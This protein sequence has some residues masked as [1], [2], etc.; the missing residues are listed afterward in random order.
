MRRVDSAVS[1]PA[2]H[3]WLS[4]KWDEAVREIARQYTPEPEPAPPKRTPADIE[5]E[6]AVRRVLNRMEGPQRPVAIARK[7]GWRTERGVVV[8]AL[9][10]MVKTGSVV[11]VVAKHGTSG[12]RR[13]TRYALA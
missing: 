8:R 10:R 4:W 7:L 3:P 5:A 2:A 9:Q 13:S 12:K 11:A 1:R 6:Y